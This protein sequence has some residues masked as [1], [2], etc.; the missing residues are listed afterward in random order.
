MSYDCKPCLSRFAPVCLAGLPVKHTAL[1]RFLPN[2]H[3][4]IDEFLPIAREKYEII[5]L[6]SSNRIEFTAD[7]C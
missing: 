5:C 6:F 3:C 7:S 1:G 2:T 4:S